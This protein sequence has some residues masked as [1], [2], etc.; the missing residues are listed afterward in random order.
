M[1]LQNGSNSV[2]WQSPNP[3]P[4]PRNGDMWIEKTAS[5][6]NFADFWTWDNG[7]LSMPLYWNVHF[8]GNAAF[9]NTFLVSPLYPN[10]DLLINQWII[11][12]SVFSAATDSTNQWSFNLHSLNGTNQQTLIHSANNAG[13]L[14][15]T[16]QRQEFGEQRVNSA[17]EKLLRITG[18]P[19][20][21][22]RTVVFTSSLLYQVIRP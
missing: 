8:N 10:G 12:S 21:T 9:Q 22:V 2:I 1:P 19:G 18:T 20:S 6:G 17:T 5:F 16:N 14:A 4:N 13:G 15:N 11:N 3:P 7:W